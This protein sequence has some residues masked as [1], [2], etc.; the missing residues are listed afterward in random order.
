MHGG[1]WEHMK[2]TQRQDG[3]AEQMQVRMS[4]GMRL[5]PCDRAADWEPLLYDYAEGLADEETGAAVQRH[6]EECPYCRGALADIQ[7]MT[8]ALKASVPEPKTDLSARVME[9]IRAQEDINGRVFTEQIDARTGRTLSSPSDEHR[10]RRLINTVGYLAASLLLVIGLF[11]AV[12]L[13]RMRSGAASGTQEI[14]HEQQ[15][16]TP[17]VLLVSGMRESE[18]ASLLSQLV[19][20]PDGY[21]ITVTETDDGFWL[22]PLSALIQ[23]TAMLESEG[24]QV[25]ETEDSSAASVPDDAFCIRIL[26]PQ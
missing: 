10:I 26:E 7:W 11:Y 9:T 16:E 14:L 23:V 1:E 18:L 2:M 20:T 17:I 3:G 22:E 19:V 6:L 5:Q 8:S 15:S 24:L 12:P 4:D 25:T 21:S 13:L